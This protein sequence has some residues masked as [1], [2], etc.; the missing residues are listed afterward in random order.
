M[1]RKARRRPVPYV[2]HG[3][4]DGAVIACCPTRKPSNRKVKEDGMHIDE[5]LVLREYNYT[6]ND[7]GPWEDSQR[8]RTADLLANRLNMRRTVRELVLPALSRVEETLLAM[9]E[10]M[11]CI[12]QTLA[13]L[14]SH[15]R[16]TS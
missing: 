2:A 9:H 1:S 10:Q 5:D 13:L 12:E 8:I 14:Q 7:F 4:P 11:Q 3:F 15:S 6:A 16:S